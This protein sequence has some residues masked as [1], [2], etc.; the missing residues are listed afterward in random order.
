MTADVCVEMSKAF[1]E[2][3][4]FDHWHLELL[5]R[6][7]NTSFTDSFLHVY[8]LV[9]AVIKQVLWQQPLGFVRGYICYNTQYN[10]RERLF[11]FLQ[12]GQY[13]NKVSY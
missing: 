6:I 7:L 8:S 12:K 5:K 10:A 1:L 2:G 11:P 4:F 9:A 3:W 13:A